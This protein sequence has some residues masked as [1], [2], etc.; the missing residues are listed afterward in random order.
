MNTVFFEDNHTKIGQNHDFG[1]C[2]CK[3][4]HKV[5]QPKPNPEGILY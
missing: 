4:W 5:K 1:T 3:F 2:F